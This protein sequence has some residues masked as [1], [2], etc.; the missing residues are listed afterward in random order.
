VAREF[1]AADC[2]TD[3]FK[4]GRMPEPFLFGAYNGD[5]YIEFASADAFVEFFYNKSVIVYAHNGGKFDWHFILDHLEPGTRIQVINGRLA[6]FKIGAAEFRDSYSLLPIPLSAWN[7]DE[8]DYA[9]FE[10]EFRDIPK[11]RDAIRKYLKSDCKNLYEILERFFAGYGRKLTLAGASMSKWREMSG[12]VPDNS[13]ARF[14]EEMKPYYYGGR[15]EC[16]QTGYKREKF[17]V[18]DINSA[19]PFAMGFEHPWGVLYFVDNRLPKSD[20]EISRCFI[21]IRT[22]ATGA[23]PFRD[24]DGSLSFPNDHRTRTFYIT[25][26][27]YIAARDT[28]T[29]DG[30]SKVLEVREFADNI[31]FKDYVDHFFALKADAKERMKNPED[32]DAKADYIFAKLFMNS[33]YG[34]FASNPTSYKEYMTCLPDEI[35]ALGT[36]ELG[37]WALVTELHNVAI[38]SRALPEPQQRFFNVAVGASIT[39]FVRAHLWRAICASKTPLYCD[40]DSLAARSASVEIGDELGLWSHEGAFNEYAIAGKKLYAFW[41]KKGKPKIASKGVKISAEEIKQI[42]LGQEI[43]YKQE[44]P[45]FG[46]RGKKFNVRKIKATAKGK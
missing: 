4:H 3:P 37:G 26:W 29:L 25:G 12:E 27:E 20:A 32:K 44:A 9:L 17:N 11:N 19:Y 36:E 6:K 1:W 16:F 42:A 40:T 41:P 31:N 21:T 7:K 33:L 23:F 39:G 13:S 38:V 10:P 15:V 45:T 24:N 8:I 22:G 34:K 5:E 30:D 14:Y 46:L 43:T 35:T 18:Y 28:G 2:E